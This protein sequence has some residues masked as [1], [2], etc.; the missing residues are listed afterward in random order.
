MKLKNKCL[1]LAVIMLL[2]ASCTR[3]EAIS[4][5][6]N[7]GIGNSI[8][9]EP[10]VVVNN[11]VFVIIDGSGSGVS[12]ASVPRLEIE[13]LTFLIDKIHSQGQGNIWLT[14]VAKDA[15]RVPV[16]YLNIPKAPSVLERPE[17]LSG[18]RKGDFDRR[19]AQFELKSL[20][21]NAEITDLLKKYAQQKQK[22][23][24]DAV[25]MMAIAYDPKPRGTDYSDCI[26]SINT[27]IRSLT[28][29]RADDQSFRTILFVSDGIQDLPPNMPL[30][31]LC[32]IP[33]D[34][35]IFTVNH[36]GSRENI[37]GDISTEVENPRRAIS[38]I[39]SGK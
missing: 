7:L 22:F 21:R 39:F 27:A 4:L 33:K 5:A 31:T 17:R 28:T 16:I 15:Y 12:E 23:L 14:Y 32:S 26:G 9:V 25:G 20:Q 24:D 2:S 35:S 13:E 8:P 34:V 10:S 38:M 18:E 19:V 30:K 3:E 36:S 11:D 29:S 37:V 6:R 1:F